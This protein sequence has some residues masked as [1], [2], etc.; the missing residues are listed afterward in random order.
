MKKLI[1]I[2]V[3][4]PD[5]EFSRLI[6]HIKTITS[7]GHSFDVIVDPDSSEKQTFFMDGDGSFH[8][9]SIKEE[10]MGTET[11]LGTIKSIKGAKIPKNSKI[12]IASG[13]NNYFK[14]TDAKTG[15]K[16]TVSQEELIKG[17][18][19]KIKSKKV[20]VA[21]F[22]KSNTTNKPLKCSRTKIEAEISKA[23]KGD[24]ITSINR[25]KAKKVLANFLDVESSKIC[26]RCGTN[27][28]VTELTSGTKAWNCPN[29]RVTLPYN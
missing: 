24:A 29:D 26:P 11:L 22:V 21:S 7:P 19:P 4:D 25:N 23:V 1:N 18:V 28:I 16:Y 17:F 13:K 2:E 10:T 8:I 6:E 15:K 9:K 12:I 27:M 14:V 3:I 20:S 5:N